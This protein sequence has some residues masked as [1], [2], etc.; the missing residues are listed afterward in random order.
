MET[1]IGLAV[2]AAVA[3]PVVAIIALVTAIGAR[4]ELRRLALRLAAV[5]AELTPRRSTRPAA[6]PAAEPA[7]RPE[8]EPTS[9]AIPQ[10]PDAPIAPPAPAEPPPAQPPA[11]VPV[12]QP[13]FEERFGT[14]WVVRIGGLALALGGIFMVRFTIE[15]GLI[16]PGVRVFLGG[17]LAAVLIA[18]GE[19]TRRQDNVSGIAA[20]PGAHIPSILTAAG[21]TVAYATVYAA[22]G[23]YGFLAP[24]AAFVLLGIVALLTLGASLLHG[25]ALAG[26]GLVGAFV[27]P[28][29][30]ASDE[31]NYWALYVYLAVVTGAAF[32]LARIRMWRWLA[33]TAIVLGTLWM[34]PGIA[35]V[36]AVTPHAFHAVAGFAL[37]ASLIV[38]GLLWG[39]DALPGR[40]DAVSSGALAAYLFAAAMLAIASRHDGLALIV[41]AM[42][43]TA[44]V[45]AAW[46]S[47]AAAAAVPTAG[48]LVALVIAHWAVETWVDPLVLPA[49]PASGVLPDTSGAMV[50]SHLALGAFFMVLFAAGGFLAQGRSERPL[51]PMLWATTAVAGPVAVLIALYYR[52]AGFERSIPFAGIALLLAAV[53][54]VATETLGKR[55]ARPGLAASAAIFATGAI[56]ALALALTFALEKGW[57]TVA[58]GLMVPGI[59]WVA[60]QRPLPALRVVAAAGAALVVVRVG[61]NPRVVGS[62]VGTTPIFNWL[63]WGY[64]APAA[65][66]WLGGHLLRRRGDDQPARTVDAAAILFTV[67]LGFLELRHLMN[68]GDVYRPGTD[69]AELSLQVA[70]GLALVIG[71]ERIRGRTGSIVHDIGALVVAALVAIGVVLG[72][73]IVDNPLISSA[74]VGGP[75]V[76]LILLGYGL[77]AVLMTALALV[78]RATRPASYRIT[79]TV[80]AVGLALAYFTFEVVRLFHGPV[81]SAGRTTNAEQYTVSAVWLAFGVALLL[82]G[83]GLRSQ[84]TRLASAAIVIITVVKVFVVD[85]ASL[86]GF[87]RAL[88]FIGLGA[89]LIGIALLYQRLLFPRR[90]PPALES[91]HPG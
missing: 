22:Y 37:V 47:D 45:A 89:V 78:T 5:E 86:D 54:A 35:D 27:T 75:F 90:A 15:Q 9:A 67:L 64:G 77:N 30:V 62:D 71:L 61:W 49:G 59:A 19:W 83:I 73:W 48:L 12:A 46:R 43:V 32:G 68:G 39:P 25:P 36:G 16:G 17:L 13:G 41:F 76:N 14:R 44:A 21:T 52:I 82:V 60:L 80:L 26:L 51:P 34:L 70:A 55:P 88:S 50:G 23:L 20:L 11:I 2:L 69:L 58:L 40:V 42:L 29:L 3:M 24:A 79:A 28:L 84:P 7:P 56:A 53:Y 57:L 18:A 63:L 81:L 6:E 87:F 10:A 74:G 1:L 65:A 31:P 8:A 4:D 72:L 91:V 85:L 66:F 33:V 38:A